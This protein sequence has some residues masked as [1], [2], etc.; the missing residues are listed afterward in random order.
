MGDDWMTGLMN[1]QGN[2]GQLVHTVIAVVVGF[3]VLS[4]GITLVNNFQGN[5]LA[6]PTYAVPFN[7]LWPLVIAGVLI[8][9][10]IVSIPMMLNR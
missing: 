2:V 7:T 9:G 4:L 8:L 10:V 3:M 6:S 1:Q 5:I